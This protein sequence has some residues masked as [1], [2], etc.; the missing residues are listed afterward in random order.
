MSLDIL[1]RVAIPHEVLASG[2]VSK[3][4]TYAATIH[5]ERAVPHASSAVK[6][7]SSKK[8]GL[9]QRVKTFFSHRENVQLF[10]C[11][12][13]LAAAGWNDASTGPLIPYIESYYRLTYTV[14]STM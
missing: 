9:T 13:A 2:D 3:S 7:S 1:P 14:V 11:Y 4:P 5:S 8:P 12:W 6:K 10:A